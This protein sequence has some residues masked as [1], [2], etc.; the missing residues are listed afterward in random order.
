MKIE[1][2]IKQET[3]YNGKMSKQ[4]LIEYISNTVKQITGTTPQVVIKNNMKG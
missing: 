1:L 3:I 2:Y 4:D